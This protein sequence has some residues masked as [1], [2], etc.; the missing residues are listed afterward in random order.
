MGLLLLGGVHPFPEHHEQ[1]Q[2][3]FALQIPL[4]MKRYMVQRLVERRVATILRQDNVVCCC[5]VCEQSS[6]SAAPLE[7]AS[8]S[9][10]ICESCLW[11]HVIR[12]APVD[13]GCCVDCPLCVD[14]ATATTTTTDRSTPLEL[15]TTAERAARALASGQAFAALPED[16]QA[17]KRQNKKKRRKP[18]LLAP[19]WTTAVP[20][21]IGYSQ[22]VRADRF[23]SAVAAQQVPIVRACL[24]A[25]MYVGDV[26]EGKTPLLL[27]VYSNAVACVRLLLYYGCDVHEHAAATGTTTA[28][29]VAVRWGYTELMDLL[30]EAGAAVCGQS[31]LRT[32]QISDTGGCRLGTLVDWS[33]EDCPGAGSFVM[34][35]FVSEPFMAAL[36]SVWKTL[37][38][39][40]LPKKKEKTLC[41]R[42]SYYFDA[43]GDITDILAEAISKALRI[44]ESS[45][46][47]D[48]VRVHPSMRFLCYASSG[49]ILAPHIDLSRTDHH[50]GKTSTHSFLF[51]MT[52]CALGGETVLLRGLTGPARWDRLATVQPRKGRLLLFPHV[53]PH[54]GVE[55]ESVPK[56][57]IRGEVY[58]PR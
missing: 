29:D 33:E 14:D 32:H 1:G 17:L 47:D 50:T 30:R 52:D 38:V 53:C 41:S 42:R 26:R 22:T 25:G 18:I 16:A 55:V 3:L 34:D 49:A 10:S 58:I 39:E 35:G 44:E 37:P 12:M 51:Y 4:S 27:A 31:V 11:D 23:W 28:W 8:C 21:L 56:L 2:A 9:H 54:E 15:G 7:D 40:P 5:D 13:R 45:T 48:V 43:C 24:E 36:V 57:L 20:D 19:N 46:H 6:P